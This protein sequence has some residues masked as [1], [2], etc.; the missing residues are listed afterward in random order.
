MQVVCDQEVA[1][2]QATV[3]KSYLQQYTGATW[4]MVNSST[5]DGTVLLSR[6]PFVSSEVRDLG[7]NSW[8][9]NRHGVRGEINVGGRTVNVFCVH[10]DYNP[11][12][13][14]TNHVEN[15]TRLLAWYDSIAGRKVVY[16][17]LNAWTWGAAT[18]E[19]NEQRMTH[20]L[21][22]QRMTHVCSSLRGS[23]DVCNQDVTQTTHNWLPDHFYRTTGL[24]S[25]SYAIVPHGGLSDHNLEVAEL[26]VE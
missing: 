19:G 9:A 20:T 18:S 7:G 4:Y 21:L 13:I 24:A 2:S 6:Y 5:P 15:R 22:G 1:P 23:H 8:G 14:M 11:N 26:D 10:L 25:V 3:L 16:G 12:G 17:D